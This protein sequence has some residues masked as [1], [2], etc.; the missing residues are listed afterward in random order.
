MLATIVVSVTTILTFAGLFYYVAVLWSARSFI[1]RRSSPLKPASD[2]NALPS[3]PSSRNPDPSASSGQAVGYAGVSILKPVKGLDPGMYDAFASHCRQE[4]AGDY[5]ILFGVSSL[6]DSSEAPVL[7]A[8]RRLIAEFPERAIRLIETP[9]RLGP[10]GKMGNVVQLAQHAR[11]DYLIVNDSDIRV[12]S[13]YLAHIMEEFRNSQGRKQVGLVTAP[14]RGQAHGTLGSKLEALGI[15]TDFFPGVLVALKMDGEIR[16]GLGSTLAVSKSA[17]EAIGGF[18][19]LVD[20]LADDY[21]LGRRV[22]KAGY[23]VV[24]SREVV[25]TSVPAYTLSGYLAHQLR[26]ARGIRDSRRAGYL[27]LVFTY[28]LPWALLNWVASGFA[29]EGLALL[30]L[31]LLARVTVALGVGIGILNDWQVMRDLWLI[32]VRDLTGLA[33]WVWSFAGNTVT[34][35]GETFRLEKGVLKRVGG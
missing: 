11:H 20:A 9:E 29:I 13:R 12:G 6:S 16:F 7:E 34:W 19:P 18:A 4:Y 24:L 21:E 10:N 1:R 3:G 32:P 30:S 22:A 35:R 31:A 15:S 5:E 8:I 25:E 2:L 14:Y 23:G 27:G 28:G 17:L 33:V 26:W